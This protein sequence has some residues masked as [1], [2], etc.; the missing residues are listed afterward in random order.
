MECCSKIKIGVVRE[1][2]E[3]GAKWGGG[4]WYCLEITLRHRISAVRS[5]TD[6]VTM[7][8]LGDT[9]TFV[10]INSGHFFELAACFRTPI[11]KNANG[12]SSDALDGGQVNCVVFLS[13]L[14]RA[15]WR[16]CALVSFGSSRRDQRRLWNCYR[17]RQVWLVL[18]S[19]PY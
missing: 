14:R 1:H 3:K 18:W 8:R 7:P 16:A 2:S 6:H 17:Y 11:F 13:F 4:S 10:V 12:S 15:C 9:S 5:V 19:V